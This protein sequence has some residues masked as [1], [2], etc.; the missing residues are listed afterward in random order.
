MCQQ[1]YPIPFDKL[2]QTGNIL[3]VLDEMGASNL[4]AVR[5]AVSQNERAPPPPLCKTSAG[6]TATMYSC[7][8]TDMVSIVPS[9]GKYQRI[10]IEASNLCL[11]NPLSSSGNT[12]WIPCTAG[13]QS[14]D[15]V[16]DHA[17]GS[18]AIHPREDSQ[19]CLDVFSQSKSSGTPI[20]VWKCNSGENQQW[21]VK[22]Q[23]GQLVSSFSKLC[24]SSC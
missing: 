24:L 19:K 10:Q 4:S 16:F 12:T 20:D 11:R 17:T 6:N 21:A 5:L 18:G 14:Q 13:D 3:T 23:E 9:D 22:K 15:W 7:G 8:R 1:Y 2:K